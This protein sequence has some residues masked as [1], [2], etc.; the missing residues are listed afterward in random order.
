M[1]NNL[2]EKSKTFGVAIAKYYISL[3]DKRYY[4]I[5]SQLFRS[6][7]SI[8]ANIAEA[9]AGCSKKDFINKLYIALKE[10]EETLYRLDILEEWFGEDIHELRDHCKELVK[11]LVTI[12]KH[13]KN[14]V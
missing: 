10:G 4:E 2:Q 3:K 11:I 7:T 12:I 13:S 8:G 14:N 5:A 9:W 1:N 6:G